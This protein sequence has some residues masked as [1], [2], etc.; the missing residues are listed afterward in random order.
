AILAE[1]REVEGKI[2]P[3]TIKY[4]GGLRENHPSSYRRIRFW[5]KVEKNLSE[6]ELPP[7]MMEKIIIRLKIYPYFSLTA[8]HK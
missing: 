8:S 3:K 2:R 1:N 5:E 7:E 6:L 4:P